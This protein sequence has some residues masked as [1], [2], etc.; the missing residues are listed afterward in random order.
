MIR[1][2]GD[3]AER[4]FLIETAE[5]FGGVGELVNPELSLGA[6]EAAE[7]P[8]G[9]DEV[10]DEEAFGGGGGLPL[11]VIVLGE[12]FE[13]AGVLAG[14]DLRFGFKAG[15]EGVEAGDGFSFG[16]ARARGVLRVPTVSFN[17]ELRRHMLSRL[18]DSGRDGGILG[19]VGVSS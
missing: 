3:L 4:S 8:I 19:G 5:G 6:A 16:R 11:E 2:G 15:F 12:G 14:D 9:A 18:E 17:L 7:L 10:I 1:A 13:F